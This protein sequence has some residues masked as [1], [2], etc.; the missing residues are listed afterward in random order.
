MYGSN[1]MSF[2]QKW[3]QGYGCIVHQDTTQDKVRAFIKAH[4]QD[5]EAILAL[6]IAADRIA[7]AAMWLVVHQA[8]A[9]RVSMQGIL[10][11]LDT[12]EKTR[13]LGFIEQGGT[14]DIEG[15]QWVNQQSWKHI[16]EATTSDL[17]E[18]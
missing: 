11:P 1:Y 12:G 16:M 14:L 4:P 13:F 17:K 9:C 10:R 5:E 7:N 3:A 8:Y 6:F 2:Y 18:S 15:M